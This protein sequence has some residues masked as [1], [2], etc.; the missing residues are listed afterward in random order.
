MSFVLSANPAVEDSLLDQSHA[1]YKI[2]NGKVT[3][4]LIAFESVDIL[5][6]PNPRLE[7]QQR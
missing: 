3:D 2:E 4:I 7:I 6:K 1:V 5:F